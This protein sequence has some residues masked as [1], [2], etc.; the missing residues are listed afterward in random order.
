MLY[1]SAS[2]SIK[3][4]F[5][6]LVNFRK[7]FSHRNWEELQHAFVDDY[8]VGKA[9]NNFYAINNSNNKQHYSPTTKRYNELLLYIQH[10][11]LFK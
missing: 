8:F 9:E 6:V 11:I 5:Y 4:F 7:T 3:D 10:Y 2:S 1:H